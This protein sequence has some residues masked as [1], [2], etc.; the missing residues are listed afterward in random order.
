MQSDI[1]SARCSANQVRRGSLLL[2][3]ISATMT[4]SLFCFHATWMAVQSDCGRLEVYSKNCDCKSKSWMRLNV[5]WGADFAMRVDD[6]AEEMLDWWLHLFYLSP[7]SFTMPGEQLK[8]EM[9]CENAESSMLRIV[10]FAFRFSRVR[11]FR[12]LAFKLMAVEIE[13]PKNGQL[14]NPPSVFRIIVF[15]LD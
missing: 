14:H 3:V 7:S 11:R 1:S 4:Q 2:L 13:W 15:S 9:K 6:A 12:L 5:I 10:S 8:I